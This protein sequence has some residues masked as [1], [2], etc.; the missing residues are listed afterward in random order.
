MERW[1]QAGQGRGERWESACRKRMI[2]LKRA[3]RAHRGGGMGLIRSFRQKPQVGATQAGLRWPESHPGPRAQASCL[4][5]FLPD[6]AHR[7]PGVVQFVLP[8]T[9]I[10]ASLSPLRVRRASACHPSIPRFEPKVVQF[11]LPETV[12]SRAAAAM[13]Q[14]NHRREGSPGPCPQAS[15]LYHF[16]P[17]PANRAPRVCSVRSASF[18]CLLSSFPPPRHSVPTAAPNPAPIQPSWHT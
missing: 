8:K 2:V 5:H 7:A 11:V 16:L 6:P 17:D 1:F 4:C 12:F 15:C 9:A 18:S 3:Q 10:S 14:T 13:P